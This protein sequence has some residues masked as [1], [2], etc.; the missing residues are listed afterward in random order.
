MDADPTNFSARTGSNVDALLDLAEA[1]SAKV[2]G[3]PLPHLISE[4]GTS[5]KN[6][7]D[8]YSPMHDWYIL[9]GMS[10]SKSTV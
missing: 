1:Y 4:Y 3:R 9:K 10:S 8:T 2:L 7:S 5:F 6:E